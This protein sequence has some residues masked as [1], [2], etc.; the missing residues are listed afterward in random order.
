MKKSQLEYIC[1]CIFVIGIC[2]FIVGLTSKCNLKMKLVTSDINDYII[3]HNTPAPGCGFPNTWSAR[4][5]N[6]GNQ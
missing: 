6:P 2:I 4:V 3:E 1:F 5:G